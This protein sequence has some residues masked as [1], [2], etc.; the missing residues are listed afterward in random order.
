VLVIGGDLGYAGAV[1]MCAEAAA[2]SGAGLV[3]AATRTAHTAAIISAR[4]ELMCH[5]VENAADLDPLLDRATVIAIG[6]GLGQSDWSMQLLT[7]VLECKKPTVMDA[8]ALNLL[9][10]DP[11]ANPHRIITPHPGEAARLLATD[12]AAVQADRF[13]TVHALQEK[14][15]GVVVLKGSGTLI[16]DGSGT[17]V[18]TGGNPGMASG[19]MGDVLT[20]IIAG[21]LAQHMDPGTACRMAVCLHANA[22]DH[23]AFVSGERGL[24]ASDLFPHIRKALNPDT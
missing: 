1:R 22:A 11:V 18:S 13:A 16:R 19:G 3:S 2:R 21:L 6:P 20:G 7:R 8:D 15:Q 4:P 10:T 14:Y 9:A 24:L 23:A 5:G 12:T 17:A